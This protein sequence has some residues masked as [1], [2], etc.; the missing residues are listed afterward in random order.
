L[1]FGTYYH[2]ADNIH[3]YE[4]HFELAQEITKEPI[5][6]PNFFML[7]TPLF[8]M[9]NDTM[10]LTEAGIKFLNEVE[11]LIQNKPINQEQAK[12]VLNNYF[13]IQ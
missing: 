6:N 3:F 9:D 12:A 13:Y 11:T 10:N 8:T 2:C 5:K 4:R 7:K 1:E